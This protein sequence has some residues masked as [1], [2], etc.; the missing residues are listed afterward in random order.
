MELPH[1]SRADM[2]RDVD[3]SMGSEG[4]GSLKFQL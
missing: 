3:K 4:G 2:L 1:I